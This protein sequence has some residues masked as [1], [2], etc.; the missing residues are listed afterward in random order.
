MVWCV[1]VLDPYPQFLVS[2]AAV[3]S[4]FRH[5]SILLQHLLKKFLKSLVVFL[6]LDAIPKS[7]RSIKSFDRIWSWEFGGSMEML[8]LRDLALILAAAFWAKRRWSS[9]IILC[10]RQYRSISSLVKLF[11]LVGFL[12]AGG[13]EEDGFAEVTRVLSFSTITSGSSLASDALFFFFFF[14][15]GLFRCFSVCLWNPFPGNIK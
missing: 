9:S 13:G 7:Q 11:T 1:P 5:F 14:F 3:G 4:S 2:S 12:V 10:I 8:A 15:S 6:L